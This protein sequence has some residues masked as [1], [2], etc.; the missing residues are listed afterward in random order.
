M[1]PVRRLVWLSAVVLALAASTPATAG[2]LA[3][4]EVFGE[5]GGRYL[6][7]TYV[8]G[9]GEPNDIEV[10]VSDTAVIV[11]ERERPVTAADG[12]T[13][14][15][16]V[17]ATCSLM[18]SDAQ[19]GSIKIYTGTQND[20]VAVQRTGEQSRYLEIHG[21]AGDDELSA[22]GH[23]IVTLK[24]QAGDDVMIGGAGAGP[25]RRTWTRPAVRWPRP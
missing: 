5:S 12:C 6:A 18:Q 4:H 22:S 13:A 9:S 14:L 23:N 2:T 8:A 1:T 17:S 3:S 15:S 24:G 10:E 7:F 11:S 16:S 25:E 19:V 20:H 21:G